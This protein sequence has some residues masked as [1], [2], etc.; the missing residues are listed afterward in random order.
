MS[1]MH[2]QEP[3]RTRRSFS[4]EFKGDAVA[5][6]IDEGRRVI[7]RGHPTNHKRVRRL[8]A[9]HGIVGVHKPA[10]ART[11]FPAEHNPPIPDRVERR[12]AWQSWE[13]RRSVRSTSFT[14][15]RRAGCCQAPR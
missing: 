8:M 6:V 13:S 12:F 15:R 1:V 3:V 14:S 4:E 7:D 10:P 2:E 9:A 5:L 11:T